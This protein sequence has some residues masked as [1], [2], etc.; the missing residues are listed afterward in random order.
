M[1][2]RAF[3]VLVALALAVGAL[4]YLRDPAWLLTT[5]A[6][7]GPWRTDPDGTR[8]RWTAGHSSFFVP[9]GA[10][11]IDVP[12]RATFDTEADWPIVATIT[13]DDRPAERIVLNDG[14]W[15]RV[16][17]RLPPRGRRRVRR[18]DIVLDRM[19]DEGRGIQVGEVALR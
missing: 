3:L 9:A 13:I 1:I 10:A 14:A 12:L 6:G 19:R 16:A 5:T 15:R 4:A 18:I 7:F 8:F 11:A 17:I 2:R